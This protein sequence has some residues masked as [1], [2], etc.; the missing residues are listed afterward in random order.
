VAGLNGHGPLRHDRAAVVFLVD[1]MDGD[2][3][4]GDAGAQHRL[5][6]A[7]AVH[8]VPAE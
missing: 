1:Q 3:A 7:P 6:H 8:A 2:A 5:V 4:L